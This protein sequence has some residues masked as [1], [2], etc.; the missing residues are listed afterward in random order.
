MIGNE[1]K[2][3]DLKRFADRCA[4][5]IIRATW[6]W[7]T[8]RPQIHKAVPPLLKEL[9]SI[10]LILP[11]DYGL[12]EE[13]ASLSPFTW[14]SNQFTISASVYELP[15]LIIM[16]LMRQQHNCALPPLPLIARNKRWF[17]PAW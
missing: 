8:R 10:L 6:C 12:A 4:K 1:K 11:A 16:R 5:P 15:C 14:A 17:V 7:N 13:A 3:A 9:Q 2:E